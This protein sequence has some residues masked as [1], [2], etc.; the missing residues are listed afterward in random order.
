MPNDWNDV[1][2]EL[3]NSSKFAEIYNSPYYE[4][5]VYDKFSD[6]EY[7]RRWN[8][9]REKMK[10]LDLDAILFPGGTNNWSFGAGVKWLSGLHDKRA[11]SQYVVLPL[12]GEPIL[13]YAHPGIHMEA[14]RRAVSIKDVRGSQGGKF[15]YVIADYLAELGLQSGR[16]G[17]AALDRR[18]PEYMGMMT[19][20]QL[21]E[22]LPDLRYEF[23]PEILNELMLIKSEEEIEAITKSGELIVKAFEAVLEI[24]KPGVK[25]YQLAAAATHAVMDGGG[26]IHFII[27]GSSSM[28]DPKMIFPNPH[29]SHRVL[30]EGDF[31]LT[32]MTG[33]YKGYTAK[34]GQPFTIGNPTQDF[35][36]FYKEVLIAGYKKIEAHVK[37]GESFEKLSKAGSHFREMGEQS[38]PILAHGLDLITAAPYISIDQIRGGPAEGVFRPGMTFS[39]EITPL[40]ADASYGMFQSRTYVVTEKGHVDITPYPMEEMPVVPV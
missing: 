34:I 33:G 9:A 32:E 19:Y 11:I 23:L 18:G 10:E 25:E 3:D 38:R 16:I 27:L 20:K 5:A 30:K 39:I 4:D 26:Q 40:K 35:D 7:E 1:R 14:T 24:A 29:P 21:Q 36:R 12:S 13:V 17:V 28:H 22:R 8:L 6:A 37:P 15:G 31:V 2:Y